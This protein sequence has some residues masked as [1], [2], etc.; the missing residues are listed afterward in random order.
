MQTEMKGKV[1]LAELNRMNMISLAEYGWV[2]RKRPDLLL[3][4][5]QHYNDKEGVNTN[6]AFEVIKY[7]IENIKS[8]PLSS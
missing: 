7:E 3:L 6:K 8:D 4:L 5:A 1:V 2:V